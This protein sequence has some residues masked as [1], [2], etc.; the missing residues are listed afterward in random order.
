MNEQPEV[1]KTSNSLVVSTHE[2]LDSLRN[3]HENGSHFWMARGLMTVLGYSTWENFKN[4]IGRAK[5][6]CESTGVDPNNHFRDTTKMI[7]VGK[8]A[9]VPREDCYLSKY[10][11][12]LVAMNGDPS[13]PA[14]GAAQ[15]YFVVQTAKQERLDDL[16]EAEKR[17]ELRDRVADHNKQLN[18]AAKDAGVPSGKFGLFHDAGYRGLYEMSYQEIKAKK[19]IAASDTVLDCAGRVELAANEFRI[20]QTEQKLRVKNVKGQNLAISTHLEVGKEVRATIKRIG[21]PMPEDLPAEP[22]IRKLK[23]ASKKAKNLKP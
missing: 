9:E 10:A 6:S 16:V 4:A 21:G 18:A 23:A 19:G 22:H 11:C 3:E 12:Y 13:K 7:V 20:T 17:I 8:G 15:A 5:M 2:R 1:P 14:I